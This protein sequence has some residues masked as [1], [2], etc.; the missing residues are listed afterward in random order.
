MTQP[1]LPTAAAQQQAAVEVFAQY[2]PPLYEAYLEMM[3]EWLAAVKVAMFA[4]GVARLGLI[5]DPLTVFSQTPKWT[6][7]TTQYAEQVAREV[8]AAPYKDLFANGTLFESRPFVRN[9]IA[10]RENRLQAV[11]N[12]VFGLVSQIIDSATVN[13]ASI[14]DVTA[15][16]EELFGDTSIPKWKNR[17]RT[18]ARTEVVGAYN[19]GLHDAFAMI[20]ANDPDTEWVKRW[21]ATEDQRTRPDHREADGQTVPFAQPFIVGGFQMMHPHDPTA[22]PKEV[23]NCR[24][25]E[26]L[27]EA[28]EPTSMEN[29][30]YKT[31]TLGSLV[32]SWNPFEK[33]GKDGKWVGVGPEKVAEAW[34]DNTDAAKHFASSADLRGSHQEDI[35]AYTSN[36]YQRVNEGLRYAAKGESLR[37]TTDPKYRGIISGLD[38]AMNKAGGSKADA[39]LYR[40]SGASPHRIL[41]RAWNDEADNTGLEFS[42]ASFSSTTQRREV[43]QRAFSAGFIMRVHVPKGTKGISVEANSRVPGEREVLLDRGL[44]FRVVKDHGKPEKGPRMLD[45]EVV[46][47]E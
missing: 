42:A 24:C 26:L 46:P 35:R 6:A 29:R 33:R 20:V 43:A 27:E 7:L 45:V 15:Q 9:W 17:A 39:V 40:G 12:E 13:G 18:V 31:S 44:R 34:K 10:A 30:G 8:L 32:A 23:I 47:S 41:G 38:S 21:L 25:V 11:P 4:G 14:P 1:T 5:P 37:K 36:A 2:E 22:P 28:G 19:G 3:L 16:V